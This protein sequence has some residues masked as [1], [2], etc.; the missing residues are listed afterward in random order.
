M[1][2]NIEHW[3]MP[4]SQDRLIKVIE[5]VREVRPDLRQS[6]YAM[7]PMRSY[8]APVELYIQPTNPTYR[9]RYEQWQTANSILSKLATAMD[10]ITPSIYT[11][12]QNAAGVGRHDEFWFEYAKAN[13]DEAKKYGKQVIPFMSP[14]YWAVSG[15]PPIAS[16]LFQRQME[17]ALEHADGV[18]MFDWVNNNPKIDLYEAM[19]AVAESSLV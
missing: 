17:F 9:S 4:G 16:D 14:R 2:W 1:I 5:W 7:A 10:F 12:Y 15:H 11:F 3:P 13:L 19:R 6:V 8:W 18:F